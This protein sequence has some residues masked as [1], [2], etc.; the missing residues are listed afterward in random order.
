MQPTPPPIPPIPN[1]G[2]PL[3]EVEEYE[4][5]D[6]R[7]TLSSLG[8]QW[9]MLLLMSAV[10]AIVIYLIDL[11]AGDRAANGLLNEFAQGKIDTSVS[12]GFALSIISLSTILLMDIRFRRPVNNLQYFLIGCAIVCFYLLMLSYAELINFA[13]SYA[14][15]S[16]MTMVLIGVFAHSLMKNIRATLTVSA[17]LLGEYAILLGLLF[18]GSFALLA[19]SLILFFLIALAMFFTQRM[20]VVDGELFLN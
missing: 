9:L 5:V 8:Q 3:P 12:Y 14:I 16:V 11:L 4:I 19:G 13:T 20:K 10:A 18:I 7:Y 2:A 6:T 17:V 15:S 1:G